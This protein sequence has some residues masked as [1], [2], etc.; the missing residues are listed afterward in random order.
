MNHCS[1]RIDTNPALW[2]EEHSFLPVYSDGSG[3][4]YVGSPADHLLR[5]IWI[6]RG[7]KLI[8]S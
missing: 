6:C 8:G 1:L 4:L 3:A 2:S 7:S 5:I